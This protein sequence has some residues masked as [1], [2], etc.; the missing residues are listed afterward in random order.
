MAGTIIKFIPGAGSITGYV[1]KA[2]VA[3][4]VTLAMGYAWMAVNER[5]VAMSEDEAAAFLSS[6][7]VKDAFV[8]AFKNAWANRKNLSEEIEDQPPA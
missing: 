6:D 3:S 2:S 8:E 5:L 1:I 4:S 7:G